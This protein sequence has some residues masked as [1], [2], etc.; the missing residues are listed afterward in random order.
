MYNKSKKYS[1][2]DFGL[3]VRTEY[4]SDLRNQTDEAKPSHH[5]VWNRL[6]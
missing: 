1:W 3:F 6:F 2:V 5:R 4:A